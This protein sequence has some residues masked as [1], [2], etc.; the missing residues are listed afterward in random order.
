MPGWIRLYRSSLDHWLYQS[1]KP[2]TRREAW[3]DI[4][5]LVNYEDKKVLVR[6]QLYDCRRGQAIYSLETWASLFN[7]SK[8]QVRTFFDLLKNDKMIELEGLQYTTRLTV[9]NYDIYQ[10]EQHTN[11][12]P[13]TH[14]QHA[15][16]TPLT[17]T[18]EREELKEGKNNKRAFTPPSI[19]EIKLRMTERGLTSFTAEAFHAHYTANGWMVGKNK[20]KDWD[21]ALTTWNEKSKQ[22]GSN[23]PAYSG[24]SKDVNNQW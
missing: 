14:E 9:C 3:E 13:I 15:A 22:Y 2:R 17:S 5:M 4:L 24:Q 8:Q 23:R 12:T 10:S 6:G 19:S 16:N 20:M 21:A 11:N 7:W 1:K 18:K